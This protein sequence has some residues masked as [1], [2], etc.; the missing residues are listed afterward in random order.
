M[1]DATQTTSKALH[2]LLLCAPARVGGLERVVQGLA[3][4]LAASGHRVTVV[5]L[6]GQLA[7]AAAFL[8]PLEGT[9]VALVPQVFGAR[10]Y[11]RERRVVRA[12]LAAHRPDVLHTH[13]YRTDLMHGAAARR[14]GIATVSTVH[15]S[16]RM[17]GLTHF[18][19]WLQLR[20]LRR[21]DGVAAVSSPL[22]AALRAVGVRDERLRLIPNALDAGTGTLPRDAARRA[23][24]LPAGATPVL[25]WVGRLVAVK[26]AD[27]FIDALAELATRVPGPWIASI[28]GDGPDR[29]A[30]ERRAAER[31]LGDRVRFHGEVP[32]A[33]RLL[34]AFDAFTL[35]SHSEGTP[36]AV[37]EA[38]QA[39]VPVVATRVGGV[40][41]LVGD[42]RSGWLVAPAS[43]SALAEGLAAA[44]GD[45]GEARARGERGR[46]RVREQND[47]ARWS[48]RY[49][50]L[51]RS[52]IAHRK[53]PG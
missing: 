35:S 9:A 10:E 53:R 2:V 34:G 45:P 15:G 25:G 3:R 23:L 39:A 24:G 6:V 17:G 38:M 41:D 1:T 18:F 30:L 13:G 37:L 11:R 33:A 12:L 47:P 29:T 36:M 50:E 46:A 16:S 21:Y 8:A 5:A 40:P 31:G 4:S 7:D 20:A 48:A 51:Y 32:A 26:A 44:L 52:A 43:P 22:H 28:V 42:E 19:E 14:A 49:E 27:V